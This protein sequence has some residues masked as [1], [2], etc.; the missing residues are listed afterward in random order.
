VKISVEVI[1]VCEFPIKNLMA[2]LDCGWRDALDPVSGV[3]HPS[4]LVRNDFETSARLACKGIESLTQ[5]RD[6]LPRR[7]DYAASHVYCRSVLHADISGLKSQTPHRDRRPQLPHSQV[8]NA[9]DYAHD[10]D[11]PGAA[12]PTRP[13]GR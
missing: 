2:A 3:V 13:A 9:T 8:S 7:D 4:H 12:G 5:R 1:L 10:Q 11:P 6:S